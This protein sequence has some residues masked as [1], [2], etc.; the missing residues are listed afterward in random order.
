MAHVLDG[1]V[2]D[3]NE[4]VSFLEILAPWSVQDL[5]HLLP[6][7]GVGDGEPK[8]HPALG[9]GDGH[10]VVGAH[11]AVATARQRVLHLLAEV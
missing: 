7:P 4:H 8:P 3:L 10:E 9:D 11:P 5:L 2:V 1:G 6:E